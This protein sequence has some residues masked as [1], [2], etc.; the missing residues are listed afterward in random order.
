MKLLLSLLSMCALAAAA[1][2]CPSADVSQNGVVDGMFTWH[3]F[4]SVLSKGRVC[5]A[6]EVRNTSGKPLELQWNDAGPNPVRVHGNLLVA[7]CCF[8]THR[9][10][11]S[12][13]TYGAPS[14]DARVQM[15][16]EPE[17]GT[18][19]REEGYP[20]LLEPEARVK[21]ISIRGTLTAGTQP[22]RVDV[23]LKCSASAFAKQFAFQYSIT[24]R[25]PDPVTVD[26]DL[27]RN[28]ESQMRPS[29]QAIPNGKTYI[30]LT[31]RQPAEAEGVIDVKTASGVLAGRFRLDG[32]QP[33]AVK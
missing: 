31:D 28:T 10:A 19:E 30:F 15:V 14:R 32:F 21:T 26:W 20:D 2:L 3:S 24:D 16:R 27:L 8:E 4:A 13:I 11:P 25:S 12:V 7:V 23:L 29:V 17:E 22:V 5:L 6:N 18:G 1:D 33:A 9:L